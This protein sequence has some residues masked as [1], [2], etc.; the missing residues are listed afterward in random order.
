MTRAIV[1]EPNELRAGVMPIPAAASAVRPPIPKHQHRGRRSNAAVSLRLA[2]WKSKV[3]Q[4]V[5]DNVSCCVANV[6]PP[7]GAADVAIAAVAASPSACESRTQ[8]LENSSFSFLLANVQGFVS[9]SAD[10]TLFE[11]N[12]GCPEIV[13]FT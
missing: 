4:D 13:G 10:L 2:S 6:T 7:N 1:V 9:K 11:E 3:S 5:V 8:G 12:Q